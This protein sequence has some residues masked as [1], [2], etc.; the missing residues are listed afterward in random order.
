MKKNIL[1]KL[2]IKYKSKENKTLL[3]V[4]TFLKKKKEKSNIF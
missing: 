3:I 1:N 2:V 4:I